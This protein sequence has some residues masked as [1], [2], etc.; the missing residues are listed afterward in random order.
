[1]KR[2]VVY[3]QET[4]TTYFAKGKFISYNTSDLL[5][6][7][8]NIVFPSWVSTSSN[9]NFSVSDDY[10]Y[11]RNS[12]AQGGFFTAGNTINLYFNRLYTAT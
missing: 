11:F 2:V 8:N 6:V 1:L 9:N 12:T 7:E 4:A 3:G 5:N 10:I